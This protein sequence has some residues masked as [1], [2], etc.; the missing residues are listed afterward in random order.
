MK[1]ITLHEMITFCIGIKVS[2]TKILICATFFDSFFFVLQLTE[3][4][5]STSTICNE[6]VLN[7]NNFHSFKQKVLNAHNELSEFAEMLP[8]NEKHQKSYKSTTDD[9]ESNEI[10]E[11][12]NW[13]T[14]QDDDDRQELGEIEYLHSDE[15]LESANDIESK[16]IQKR[17]TSTRTATTKVEK[18]RK[19]STNLH[20]INQERVT[21]QVYECL[22][23]PANLSD[24]LQLNNHTAAHESVFC[25][26]C[27][28]SFMRYSNLKR[29]FVKHHIKPKPFVCD[30]CGLG[31]LFSV[32]LQTHATLHY[33]VPT[34]NS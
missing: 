22:I 32:N 15:D 2:S 27:K 31:F 18:R 21:V 29:H 26:V 5:E 33:S 6:C 17:T 34:M 12:V 3:T 4:N 28:Q 25:K 16:P 19:V 13:E 23:C 8:A 7:V 9:D 20:E 24:I 10:H 1:S 30:V 11:I 14:S